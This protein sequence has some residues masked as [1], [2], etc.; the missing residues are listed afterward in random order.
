MVEDLNWSERTDSIWENTWGAKF[1][2]DR[3]LH[4][5]ND[6]KQPGLGIHLGL[7]R[8]AGHSE[9][10]LRKKVTG[11]TIPSISGSPL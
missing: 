5:I 9:G 11:Q 3:G 1:R 4:L 10:F 8:E 6:Q 2:D 7:S